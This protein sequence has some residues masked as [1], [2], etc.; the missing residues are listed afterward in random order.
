MGATGLTIGS[1]TASS[2]G[3]PADAAP[4]MTLPATFQFNASMSVASIN[5]GNSNPY[6]ASGGPIGDGASV[7]SFTING[8]EVSGLS[9]DNPIILNLPLQASR[10]RQLRER[11]LGSS[12]NF[13]WGTKD[14]AESY[15][16][17][18]GGI[19]VTSEEASYTAE[20]VAR[21][22]FCGLPAPNETHFVH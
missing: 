5:Y 20:D 4:G 14:V 8:L 7:N 17:N 18:C 9:K 13:S 21:A 19:N 12:W 6:E 2:S 1:A 15:S 22:E 16:V 10:R 11:R 3:L